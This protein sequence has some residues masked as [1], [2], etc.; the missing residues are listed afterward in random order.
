MVKGRPSGRWIKKRDTYDWRKHQI[1]EKATDGYRCWCL[2]VLAA[3]ADKCGRP[4][5]E[6]ERDARVLCR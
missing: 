3:Y 5:D 2:N 4:Y 1:A 6:H